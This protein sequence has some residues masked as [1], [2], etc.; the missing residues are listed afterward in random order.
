MVETAVTKIRKYSHDCSVC[1]PKQMRDAFEACSYAT[2][3]Q[4]GNSVIFTPI[5][6]GSGNE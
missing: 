2:V 1:V 6:E 4:V 3:K 5:P